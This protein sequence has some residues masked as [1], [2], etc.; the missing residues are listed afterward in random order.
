MQNAIT[1]FTLKLSR[2]RIQLLLS[3]GKGSYEEIGT[4]DPNEQNITD[5]LQILRSQV[6]ALSGDNS[7]IDVMLPDELILIQNLTVEEINKPLSKLRATELVAKAC[8]LKE[9]EINISL[10]SPTSYRTQP[11]AAVTTKTLDETRYFL[12]NAGFNTRRFTAS[13]PISGFTTAPIFL[14]DQVPGISFINAKNVTVFSICF[15]T[16]FL[17][18]T[19]TIF[20]IKPSNHLK[21]FDQVNTNV[22]AVLS[23]N[24]LQITNSN[25]NK[26]TF[27]TRKISPPDITSQ[28]LLLKPKAPN[29]IFQPKTKSNLNTLKQSIRNQKNSQT[30]GSGLSVLIQNSSIAPLPNTNKIRQNKNEFSTKIFSEKLSNIQE[31]ST[32]DKYLHL[33][34][35]KSTIQ[36]DYLKL[37]NPD[38]IHINEFTQINTPGVIVE[39]SKQS[40]TDFIIPK[41]FTPPR[42]TSLASIESDYFLGPFSNYGALHKT[43]KLSFRNYFTFSM[44]GTSKLSNTERPLNHAFLSP[45]H[46]KKRIVTF[47]DLSL[48][49]KDRLLAK[50]YMPLMRPNQISK[51][52]VLI[53]PTLSSGAITLSNEPLIRP[54][55]VMALSR[56]NPNEVKI[57][58]KATKRPSFPRRASVANNATISNII[59]LNRT[60]LIGVFG[61][62]RN[63]IALI[64]LASGR[65]IKVKVGDQF[66]GWK[67]LTID[68]DKIKLANGKKQE[69]LRLPG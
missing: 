49:P 54:E 14:E 58:A 22:T 23:P 6:N 13:Q 60:N 66:D 52:N 37:I 40:K 47:T 61:T 19:A 9:D 12:N 21:V 62:T 67:V 35:L 68:K 4:A 18:I 5:N 44:D 33:H 31:F 69:T 3:D 16:I 41:S 56:V 24:I 2:E 36:T 25:N 63:A 38:L 50:R 59:E 34:A 32:Q 48:T 1:N 57:L 15:V 55:L 30:L 20:A 45:E 42:F 51:L 53:E 8:D 39:P 65:V 11:V 29:K 7:L 28:S 10:G 17:F 46:D 26:K 64:R 27:S 43:I